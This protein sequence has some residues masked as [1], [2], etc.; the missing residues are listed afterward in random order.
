MAA[1]ER[2]MTG[3]TQTTTTTG[4]RPTGE[5]RAGPLKDGASIPSSRAIPQ[6]TTKPA[7]TKLPGRTNATTT[8]QMAATPLINT[9][10]IQ[11][12]ARTRSPGSIV[13]STISGSSLMAARS[14]AVPGPG[15]PVPNSSRTVPVISRQ[16]PM[17]QQVRPPAGQGHASTSSEESSSSDLSSVVA[18]SSTTTTNGPLRSTTA[19]TAASSVSPGLR[20]E[21]KPRIPAPRKAPTGPVAVPSL[22][23]PP[24][25][26]APSQLGG[27]T[28]EDYVMDG[29]AS[30]PLASVADS[31][32]G[33]SVNGLSGAGSAKVPAFLNKLFR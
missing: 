13:P 23:P 8:T 18:G 6:G 3:A 15:V 17:M 22:P 5:P 7:A 11:P 33:A 25:T 12:R 2:S 30:P 32:A 21:Q 4:T 20:P 29:T 27:T 31:T 10:Q 28:T 24:R 16:G 14:M 9:Q 19:T 26:L 1:Q